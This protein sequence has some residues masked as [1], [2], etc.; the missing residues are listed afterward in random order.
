[1]KSWGANGM[2]FGDVYAVRAQM[3][4]QGANGRRSESKRQLMKGYCKACEILPELKR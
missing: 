2:R 1:M 3:E 4:M